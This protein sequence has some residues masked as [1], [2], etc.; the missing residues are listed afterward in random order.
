VTQFGHVLRV[1][2]VVAINCT[3]YNTNSYMLFVLRC[4]R[5]IR[6]CLW[7]RHGEV[8]QSGHG[9]HAEL[10]VVNKRYVIVVHLPFTAAA[11]QQGACL[12]VGCW[13]LLVSHVCLVSS[14]AGEMLL[15]TPTFIAY[16]AGT[17]NP[18]LKHVSV[19]PVVTA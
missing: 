15:L 1:N 9:Q 19:P 2:K 3:P 16:V 17:H 10:Y 12:S 8:G 7:W 18:N 13:H 6:E 5:P 11:W 14:T 4:V